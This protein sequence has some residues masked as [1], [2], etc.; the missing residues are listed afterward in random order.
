MKKIWKI[1]EYDNSIIEKIT[2]HFKISPIIAIVLYNRGLR[3]IDQIQNFLSYNEHEFYSPFLFKDAEIAVD[4]IKEIV[5]KGE[6]IAVFGD[7][8]VDGITSVAI[9]HEFFTDQ[10]KYDNVEYILPEREIGY[11]LNSA[12]IDRIVDKGVSLLITVDC[13]IC[14]VDEIRRAR[15]KGIKVIITDHHE[16]PDDIPEAEAVINPKLPDQ[17]PISYLAGVGVAF[18]VIQACLERL[19]LDKDFVD[20]IIDLV[21]LGTIADIVPVLDENRLITKLGLDKM[22]KHKR[23]G[24]EAIMKYVYGNDINSRTISFGIAPR[25]NAS[26]RIGNPKVA[27]DLLITKDKHE[28]QTLAKELNDQNRKRQTIEMG[29][30]KKADQLV[31]ED[32]LNEKVIIL[33]SYDWNIGVI[34]VVS[35]KLK[36]NYFRPAFL[37]SIDK[38]SGIGK[39][40]ARSVQGFHLVESLNMCSDLLIEY[41]G[42]EFAAGFTIKEE[43]I[44]AFHKRLVDIFENEQAK[45]DSEG[46]TIEVD[47]EVEPQDVN[48]HLYDELRQKLYPY[49]EKNPFP[50]FAMRNVSI[51][52]LNV[53]SGRHLSLWLT[54]GFHNIKAVCYN[55]LKE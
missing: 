21:A 51:K 10:L 44:P 45:G 20:K 3:D 53:F 41:G 25:I 46:P 37:I 17:Y 26:G 40:S 13:G 31:K 33:S 9:F 16:I 4:L 43:N 52:N 22:K 7:Y 39:G 30:M 32:P 1:K 48:M 15:E 55:F 27:L 38:E 47:M 35:S 6:K 54:D 50:R 2:S 34:G 19:E 8:D 29:I 14:N 42:H 23:P 28:A 11:G 12:F 5:D 49:G 18:K 36:D 24:I